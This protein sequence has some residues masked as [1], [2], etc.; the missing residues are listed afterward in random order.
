M[1]CDI[2]NLGWLQLHRRHSPRI[3]KLGAALIPVRALKL[4]GNLN[5]NSQLHIL[6]VALLLPGLYWW[7]ELSMKYTLQGPEFKQ[8]YRQNSCF[9]WPTHQPLLARFGRK[10]AFWSHS[11]F[12]NHFSRTW[13]TYAHQTFVSSY[14]ICSQKPR[15][16]YQYARFYSLSY[17]TDTLFQSIHSHFNK[18]QLTG[19]LNGLFS[20]SME[21]EHM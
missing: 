19:T 13:P 1:H 18:N 21:L 3:R 16:D 2:Q 20:P 11:N 9:N 10:S 5:H 12:I 8:L 14:N 7:N 4:I 15:M 17:H 6:A